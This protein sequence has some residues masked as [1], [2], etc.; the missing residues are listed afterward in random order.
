[1]SQTAKNANGVR[2]PKGA[3][4]K[5]KPYFSVNGGDMGEQKSHRDPRAD[6]VL[7]SLFL[8]DDESVVDAAV[9]LYG[10]G[11]KTVHQVGKAEPGELHAIL[12]KEG[13]SEDHINA[14][15]NVVKQIQGLSAD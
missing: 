6:F 4:G 5:I 13:V 10:H 9:I 1:M 14:F 7:A 12:E 3:S 11:Y 2:L 8:G 15:F